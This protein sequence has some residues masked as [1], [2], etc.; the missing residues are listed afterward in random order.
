MSVSESVQC[1]FEADGNH[2][3]KVLQKIGR[4]RMVKSLCIGAANGEDAQPLISAFQ[5]QQRDAAKRERMSSEQDLMMIRAVSAESWTGLV[6]SKQIAKLGDVNGRLM[7]GVMKRPF[8]ASVGGN[9]RRMFP[10]DQM[11]CHGV[12]MHAR[13]HLA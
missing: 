10:V 1:R 2:C 5:R 9:P 8:D 3:G 7:D 6:R 12:P 11:Q 4:Q 13:R